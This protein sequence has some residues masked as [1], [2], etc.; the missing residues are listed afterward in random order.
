MSKNK[1]DLKNPPEPRIIDDND[2]EY[3]DDAESEE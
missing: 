1:Y 3:P 2:E